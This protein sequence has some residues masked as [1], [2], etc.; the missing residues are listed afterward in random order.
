MKIPIR[1]QLTAIYCAVF[2]LSTILLEIGAYAGLT[3]SI[4][5]VLDDELQARLQGVVGFLDEHVARK[6]LQQLKDEL[7]THAAL[8][9]AFLEIDRVGDGQLFRGRLMAGFTGGKPAKSSP[10]ISTVNS[11]RGPLRVLSTRR[12]IQNRQYDLYLGVS[13]AASSETLRRFRWLV[14]LSLPIVFACASI[15]GYWISKRA[16]QPVSRLT[17]AARRIGAANLS[18][19]LLVPKSGDEVQDLAE[20]LNRMLGRIED[21]FRHVTQFTANASHELRTPL[22]LIRTTSEVALLRVNGNA[23][24]YREALHR[25]LREAEKNSALLDDMLRLARADASANSPV[26]KPVEFGPHIQQL[27][28][29]VL[30]LAHEKDIPLELRS[31]ESDLWVLADPEHL[32]R[33]WLILLDNAIKYTPPGGIIVV[34]WQT[35]SPESLVCEVRDTGIGIAE[36][37]LPHIFERFFRADKARSREEGG[38]GLGL[39]IARWIV[40]AHHGSIEVQSVFGQ[41]S[42]FRVIL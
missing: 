39:A 34:S 42:V 37:D 30:P 18:Q 19:R 22:A 41:G 14:F 8:E 4:Y 26:L 16:L 3:S 38:A 9:P 29:R 28:E 36:A 2:C 35:A 40:D 31:T 33:L 32:K 11:N 17:N 7:S 23:D 1:T 25:I 24:S 15:A 10:A 21:A 12:T 6:T 20:T 27:C 5:A 13:L